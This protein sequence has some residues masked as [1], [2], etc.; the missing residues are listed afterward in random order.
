MNHFLPLVVKIL[1]PLFVLCFL[2]FAAIG[3]HAQT[4]VVEFDDPGSDTWT[5]PSGVTEITVR[6][7]GGGGGSGGH[8]TGSGTAGGNGSPST[9]VNI[10]G[11]SVNLTADG[12]IG[13]AGANN[14]TPTAGGG[15]GVASGGD[16]NING[17][18]GVDGLIP[19]N[20]S[21]GGT[22]G[23]SPNGGGTQA[24]AS[25]P[26]G[27]NSLPGVTGNF[28]GGGAGGSARSNNMAAGRRATG[29]GGGGAYVEIT[30]AVSAGDEFAFTVG[31]GGAAGGG[32]QAVGGAGA[33]GKLEIEYTNLCAS[34][35][36]TY[37]DVINPSCFEGD[38]GEA[39]VVVTGGTSPYSFSWE[40]DPMITDSV[41]TGLAEG[42]YK[43]FV[44]DANEC[45]KEL[46]F[47]L[48]DPDEIM[49]A[50][51]ELNDETCPGD[52]DGS[53]EVSADGGTGSL[54]F[55]WSNSETTA[56]IT[57]LTAATY[58]LTVTDIN[59]CEAT[60]S[61][62]V[63]V[64]D[65]CDISITNVDVT[66][67]T[68]PDANDGSITVTATCGSCMGGNADIRYS[69]DNSDFSNTTGVFTGL[70]PGNYTVYIRDVNDTD[71][72]DSDGL[73]NV[74]VGVDNIPP[75]VTCQNINADLDG[76]G[77]VTIQPAD[78]FESGADNC[79]TVNLESVAPNM[80]DCN[81]IGIQ[82]VT[83]TVNDGNG[84]TNTC[85][86]DVNVRDVTPP[87]FECQD[88]TESLDANGVFTITSTNYVINNIQT[89]YEDNC[90]TGSSTF[91]ITSNSWNCNN[92]GPNSTTIFAYDGNGNETPCTITVT[93]TDDLSVC[94]P[95][96]PAGLALLYYPDGSKE[97]FPN[98]LDGLNALGAPTG[99]P[100]SGGLLRFTDDNT[101]E[102]S[103]FIKDENS[104]IYQ[105]TLLEGNNGIS[106]PS[107]LWV[108]VF[109]E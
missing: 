36:I 23:S 6:V 10:S 57:D 47:N 46:T 104:D 33:N 59:D 88:I 68:C 29:G 95:Q 12:G 98:L 41:R 101:G 14:N 54:S 66:D 105:L 70:A 11:P 73:H 76:D 62:N 26:Q 64:G 60:E 71:C 83:L 3:L 4:V 49:I 22:G 75:S 16:I 20:T 48:S 100:G 86:A 69:I 82:T 13:S 8:G 39:S 80:F 19:G 21:T 50:L 17:D 72:N 5:V 53:I 35:V 45:I 9:F 31:A 90:A 2:T 91:G 42:S 67:E 78:V 85:M 107:G 1:R 109:F 97:N 51:E 96:Y 27:D 89:N 93:I 24:G 84:N 99:T 79:G 103:Y 34:F 18:N 30:L 7:W 44:E 94:G 108:K 55:V 58:F 15:G 38:D 37:G 56:E 25:P 102:V 40:D 106:G 81:D 61:Y 52:A 87:V 32:N 43:V 74:A 77:M 28:Q 65:C 63:G 92:I